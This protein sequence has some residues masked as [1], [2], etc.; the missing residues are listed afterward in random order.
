[1]VLKGGVLRRCVSHQSGAL[2]SGISGLIKEIPGTP[3]PPHSCENTESK[4]P[5]VNQER[6]SY[7]TR[8]L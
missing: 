3:S 1:M 5:F 6:G 8:N 2:M 4:W 7:Q